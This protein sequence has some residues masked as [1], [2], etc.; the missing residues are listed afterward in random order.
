MSRSRYR[1]PKTCFHCDDAVP[2]RRIPM[3]ISCR[4]LGAEAFGIG[5]M[6]GGVLWAIISNLF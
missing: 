4:K 1:H 2:M 3:C 6:I 5:A